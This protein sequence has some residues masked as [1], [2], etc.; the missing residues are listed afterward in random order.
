MAI[1]INVGFVLCMLYSRKRVDVISEMVSLFK[2]SSLVPEAG[3]FYSGGF[4]AKHR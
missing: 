4:L 2:E 3:I 1:E